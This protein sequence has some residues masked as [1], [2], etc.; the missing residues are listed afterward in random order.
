MQAGIAGAEYHILDLTAGALDVVW[1]LT[2]AWDTQCILQTGELFSIALSSGKRKTNVLVELD[3]G[4]QANICVET[5]FLT[6][7][8]KTSFNIL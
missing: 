7:C 6:L 2:L 4:F 1:G 8:L 3:M 5:V